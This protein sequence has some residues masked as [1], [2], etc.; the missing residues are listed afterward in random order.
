MSPVNPQLLV[1]QLRNI[2][3]VCARQLIAVGIDSLEKLRKIGS[4]D[5]YLRI[6]THGVHCGQHHAAYLYALEGAIH[7][8]DW[9]AIPEDKKEEFKALTA[10]L[11]G[12]T[13]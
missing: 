9:R 3:P 11:R 2:G 5:A 8:C 7:D 13:H 4:I 12:R 1:Q 6:V 10:S